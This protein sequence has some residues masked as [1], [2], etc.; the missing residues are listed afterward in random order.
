[1]TII[2]LNKKLYNIPT[3]WNELS[4][5]QL[6]QVMDCLFVHQYSG[7]QCILKLLKI[8]CNMNYFQFFRTKVSEMEEYL[9]LTSFL[10]EER[11]NLT[12]Q[13]VPC[14]EGYYG[15]SD[16][17]GNLLMVELTF[18]DNLFLQW[19][20]DRSDVKK[21]NKFISLI[22]REPKDS[23]DFILNPDGDAR[24]EWNQNISE[25]S[26]ENVINKWPMNVKM[27]IATWFDGCRCMLVDDNDEVF[28][29]ASGEASKYG[30]ASVMMNVAENGALGTF[31]EVEKQNVHTVMM[32][33]NEWI[34]KNKEQER[35]SKQ[36]G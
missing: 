10:L 16:E 1:M 12:K 5:Q 32:H 7:E 29:G 3:T 4:Q 19:C 31:N 18:S 15:P 33:L 21:L 9:Y 20:E 11:A 28:G 36:H 8:L 17:F 25:W 2:E 27:A 14:W 35:L 13:L 34:R 22:Y 26:G 6:L 23:Y 30:L 24:S